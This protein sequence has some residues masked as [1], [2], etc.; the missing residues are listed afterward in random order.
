M[1]SQM[2]APT[3]S[4]LPA[5][6]LQTPRTCAPCGYIHM[7]HLEASI[8]ER[9]K[10]HTYIYIYIEIEERERSTCILNPWGR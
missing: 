7:F 4:K 8:R 3:M 2:E 1:P 6:P 5:S 10:Q 9:D